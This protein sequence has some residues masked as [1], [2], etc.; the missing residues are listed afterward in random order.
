MQKTVL[1]YKFQLSNQGWVKL[2][3]VVGQ[4]A[5]PGDKKRLEAVSM[6]V[7]RMMKFSNYQRAVNAMIETQLL[8]RR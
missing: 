6:M 2:N 7:A 5:T 4:K 3:E 8:E 1:L